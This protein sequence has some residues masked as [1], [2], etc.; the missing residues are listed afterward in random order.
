V[1]QG[2]DTPEIDL[3][4]RLRAARNRFPDQT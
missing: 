4:P 2:L 1:S 3:P